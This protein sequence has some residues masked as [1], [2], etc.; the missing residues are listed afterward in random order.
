MAKENE[1]IK[2]K[3]T[4]SV[5][6][7]SVKIADDVVASIAAIA[8]CEVDG[9]KR[10]DGTA[11]ENLFSKVGIRGVTRGAKVEVNGK[12]VRAAVAIIMDYGYNIPETC[13]YVQKRVKNS[14]ENMTGL[15]VVDVNIRIAG[16]NVEG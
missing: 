6:L 11:S 9:V 14:I 4:G 12:Q 15:E 16:I 1:T 3:E 13:Q 2:N 5:N 8:A 7:G 10:I